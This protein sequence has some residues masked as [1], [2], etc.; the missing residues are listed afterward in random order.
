LLR[1]R[2]GTSALLSLMQLPSSLP[3]LHDC[4]RPSTLTEE[5]NQKKEKAEKVYFY[6]RQQLLRKTN[7]DL[8][9]S[10]SR[11][12]T[13]THKNKSRHPLIFS[14]GAQKLNMTKLITRKIIE[15]HLLFPGEKDT[16]NLFFLL[17]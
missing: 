9:F 11:F 6:L 8:I 13:I 3:L 10:E 2:I 14:D 1:H 7:M 5:F 12:G 17:N 15:T 4:Y 16:F